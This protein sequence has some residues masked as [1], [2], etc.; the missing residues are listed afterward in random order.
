MRRPIVFYLLI[1]FG[2]ALFGGVAL[3]TR[4]PDA[5]IL[6]RAE[7]W[8]WI[9]PAAL[10]FRDAYRQSDHQ[11]ESAGVV[12]E[13][14]SREDVAAEGPRTR[15]EP[16][17]RTYRQQV[18]VLDG[19]ELKAEPSLDAA[20]V[21]TV[22]TLARVGKIE[23]RGDWYHVAY[24]GRS[25]WVLLEG[26]D[27][28]AE[29]PYGEKPEPP[30]PVPARAPDEETLAAARRY[31]R[32]KERA[33][34]LGPY[35]LYTDCPD[36]EL[37]AHLDAVASGLEALYGERYGRR[38]IGEPAEAVVLFQ[39]DI[40]YRLVQQRTERL[41]G[42]IS[43]GH[44]A[45]GL[46]VLYAGGRSRADV[47][48]T[49]VH[50]LAHFLNRRA[51]G[52]QLPP[53]LDEGIADDLALSRIDPDGRIHPGELSGG[54]RRQGEQ[55]RLVGGLA[56]LLRL[57]DAVRAGELPA[58]PDLMS[59]DWEDFVRSPKIQLHYAAAAFWIRYLVE[60]EGG[61][62]AAGWRAF[63]GAVAAGEPPAAETLRA[64]LDEDWSVLNARFR[65]WIEHQAARAELATGPPAGD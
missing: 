17:A 46:A 56:S 48:G 20:T 41:T 29:I 12:E 1:F 61:R 33:A 19:M 35:A 6:R 9:G 51:I 27:E 5:E 65:G 14:W 30:R 21:S 59:A 64:H 39:S 38:P 55:W 16:V 37:L 34:T 8:P 63:L 45:E 53:W 22:E 50:E 40:A 15:T 57:R 36:E 10:W 26:Y 42:L 43:A 11:P 3:L 13:T 60:G 44:N 49:V 28:N 24:R 58:V 18:W 23:R 54:R 7:S 25:G 52:P 47:A 4:Y 62:H 32:G 31:L 2:L